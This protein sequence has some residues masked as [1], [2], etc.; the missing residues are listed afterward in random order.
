MSRIE[1]TTKD[2]TPEMYR[3]GFPYR[4]TGGDFSLKSACRSVR[5]SDSNIIGSQRQEESY[6]IA[7]QDDAGWL[8]YILAESTLDQA[9]HI[10]GNIMRRYLDKGLGAHWVTD[11]SSFKWKPDVQLFIFDS[12]FE[13]DTSYRRSLFYE[14]ITRVDSPAISVILLGRA[15]DPIKFMKH[16]GLRPNLM[17]NTK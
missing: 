6:R 5:L 12:L 1:I 9:K 10:A 4:I 13:D 17:I 14:A 7:C 16:I 11:I 2:Y 15:D 3:R 8:L